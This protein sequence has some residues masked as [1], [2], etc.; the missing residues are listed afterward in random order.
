MGQDKA[1]AAF[2]RWFELLRLVVPEIV[3]FRGESK[4]AALWHDALLIEQRQ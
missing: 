3:Y 1:F 4:I 2:A